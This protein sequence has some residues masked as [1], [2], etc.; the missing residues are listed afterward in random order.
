[1]RRTRGFTLIEMALVIALVAIVAVAGFVTLRAARR[2]AEVGGVSFELVLRLQGLQTKALADQ[3]D[4]LAVVHAGDGGTCGILRPQG[5]VRL[6]VLAAP[7]PTWTL[8]AFSPANPGNLTGELVET[9]VFPRGVLLDG[10]AGGMVGRPPFGTVQAWDVDLTGDCGGARCVAF[11]FQADGTVRGERP[12]GTIV[13]KPGHILPLV[14]DLQG[15]TRG[16][17]RRALLVS[18]PSG[19]VKS[20]TY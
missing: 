1:M 14:T 15:E 11:R 16:A 10:A 12:D 5:C 4:H 3:R 8:Q 9:V 18:F 19:I 13:R 7:Q 20:Y 2:N 17:E 6:F